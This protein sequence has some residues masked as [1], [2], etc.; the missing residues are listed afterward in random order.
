MLCNMLFCNPT[1]QYY[2]IKILFR[3]NTLWS[4][5]FNFIEWRT[6]V[7][8][9]ICSNKS[10]IQDA[11][12]TYITFNLKK[13]CLLWDKHNTVQY[14]TIVSLEGW[15]WPWNKTKKTHKY[16]IEQIIPTIKKLWQKEKKINKQNKTKNPKHSVSWNIYRCYKQLSY[17]KGHH[18]SFS[19][20]LNMA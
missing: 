10:Y 11:D 3:N 5:V 20:F 18:F 17:S 19:R 8:P 12:L 9:L 15:K 4:S 2:L 14:A 7:L 16:N 6:L 1:L 13:K